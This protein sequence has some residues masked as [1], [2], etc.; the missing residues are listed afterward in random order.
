MIDIN[1]KYKPLF[2]SDN[3]FYICT[4]GRGSAK[5]FS[6]SLWCALILLFEDNHTIL[7]T[8]YTM[9]SAHISIIPEFVSKLELLGVQDQFSV[10]K[11][12]IISKS[13]GSK[14][15][16][17]GLKT[18][19]GD[20]TA[21]LKSLNGVTTWI[22]DES[23]ELTDER[24]FDT[25]QLSVRSL[26]RQNRIILIMNP[27]TKVHW[28]YKRFFEDTGV[29]PGS[30]IESN[31]ITFIHTTFEDNIDNLDASYIKEILNIKK[32][33]PDK[34]QH[35]I[36]GGWLDV[37]EGVIYKNWIVG[38]FDPNLEYGYGLDFGFNPDETAMTKIAIDKVNRKIYL[39]E[40]VY[41]RDLLTND[42]INLIKPETR[43][44]EV[45]ADSSANRLIKELK[46]A[47]VNISP[48]V[49]GAGS[50]E[51]GIILMQDYQLVVS[52]NSK[53]IIK[54][55]NNYIWSNKKAGAPRDM[56]N[57]ALDGIRYY[58]SH[59]LKRSTV[60]AEPITFN[61]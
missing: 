29:Q 39:D 54:E 38:D 36:L 52:P 11:D 59:R 61:L 7:F 14:I 33:N 21:N 27:A 5:S 30:N 17:K 16:F 35:L 2:D 3:R 60:T 9:S 34:F 51:E 42:L 28:I 20:Q 58:V 55:L 53:N 4:G 8:R 49:K 18:S 45:I 24:I 23:E 57:H 46:T 15:L 41:Q 43:N 26:L 48:C 12:S 22:L 13:T 25:I 10:T 1:K 19:N 56:Y 44:K 40:K 31:D 32:N 50:I 47:G 37:A 6:I